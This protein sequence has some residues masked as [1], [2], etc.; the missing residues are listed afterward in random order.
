[1]VFDLQRKRPAA[2]ARSRSRQREVAGDKVGF[3]LQG[4]KPAVA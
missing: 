4:V 2:G 1:M 3:V